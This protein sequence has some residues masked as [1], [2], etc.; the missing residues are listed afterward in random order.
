MQPNPLLRKLG[1]SDTDRVAILHADD[2]GMCQASAAAFVELYDFG[3]VS[4][5]TVMV[6]CPWFLQAAAFARQHPDAD[7]GVHLTLTAEWPT[8]RWGPIS[9]RDPQ[10]GLIDEEGYFQHFT[11]PAM[12]AGQPAAVQVEIEAQV[13]RAIAAGMQP[14]HADTHMGVLGS[15]KFMLGYLRMAIAQRL[16][17]LLFRKDE[18]GWLAEGLKPAAAAQAAA[19]TQMLEGLGMPMLDH[20]TGLRLD[21]PENRLAQAKAAVDALQPGITHFI[22][23]PAQDTPELRAITPDWPSRVGDYQVLLSEALRAHLKAQDVHVI[24]Y[25]AMQQ[26]MPDPSLAQALPLS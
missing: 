20:M 16:P 25:R 22:F 4:S 19:M 3:L 26:H 2:V 12:Q 6:P 23:H 21:Q 8:Y 15:E 1:F 13:Q 7:L 9:T 24:G 11:W 5:G 14:T 10:S 17:P 18:A